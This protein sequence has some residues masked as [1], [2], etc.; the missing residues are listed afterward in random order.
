[1]RGWEDQI[2]FL[3]FA[4]SNMKFLFDCFT[5]WNF[6]WINERLSLDEMSSLLQNK[7][8]HVCPSL[9]EGF[10]HYLN[11]ARASGALV[12]TTDMPPMNELVRPE[13]GVLV[14]CSKMYLEFN[15][16]TDRSIHRCEVSAQDMY[17]AYL[18]VSQMSLEEK[19]ER[20]CRLRKAYEEDVLYFETMLPKII[21]HWCDL[22]KSM[23]I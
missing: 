18:I 13:A 23:F 11:E 6:K 20:G 8:V 16:E 3:T 1:V 21:N 19:K 2:G 4:S 7:G 14:P 22:P 12:I 5:C 9:A 17:S 15:P 10:G